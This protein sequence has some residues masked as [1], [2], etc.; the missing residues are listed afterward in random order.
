MKKLHVL[1]FSR[2]RA[3]QL[4]AT[5]RSL[6]LHAKNLQGISIFVLYR[7]SSPRFLIQYNQLIKEYPQVYFTQ[8]SDF[9]TDLIKTLSESVSSS[10][11]QWFQFY[12]KINGLSFLQRHSI[13]ELIIRALLLLNV[14]PGRHPLE[15]WSSGQYW[16]LSVDDNLFVRP[17]D[18]GNI[19]D[20]LETHPDAIGFSL[21]LGENITYC[22]MKNAPQR[23]PKFIRAGNDPDILIFE[24]ENAEHD[25][26]YPLEISSTIYRSSLIVPLVASLYFTTPNMLESKLSSMKKWYAKKYPKLLCYS[27]SVS[28]CNPINKVQKDRPSNRSGTGLDFS[29]DRLADL[30]DEG[31]RIDVMALSQFTPNACHQEIDLRFEELPR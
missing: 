23:I 1:I 5:L 28:F 13:V 10:N 19:I 6:F 25:F 27:L 3:L 17:I 22:Y 15:L 4:D 29:I 12:A 7:A 21:R 2:D 16:L 14:K 8:E 24:W 31:K 20:S 9:R 11:R 18:F 30:F 26:A